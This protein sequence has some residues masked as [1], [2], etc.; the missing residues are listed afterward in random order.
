MVALEQVTRADGLD[1]VLELLARDGAVIVR[2]M[3]APDVL[4]RFR[5]DMRAA[6]GNGSIGPNVDHP[7]IREFWGDRTM[8]FT[9]LAHRSRAFIDILTDPL[10]LAV[11]DATLLPNCNDYWM[12]TGQMMII[13]P[14]EDAQYL[15]RDAANWPT[16]SRPDGFEVTVSCMYA[17]TDFTAEVGATRVVPGSH[18]W[19]D[20]QRV[21]Q[22]H[23]ICQTVMPAG[24]GMIY[25]GR[26]LH[27]AGANVTTDTTR[28]GL[29]LS[30]VLGWLTP[31]EA[32]PLGTPWEDVRDHGPVVQRLLGWRCS[33]HGA[34]IWTVDYND[35]PEG[36]G[37]V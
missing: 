13:A 17:V 27:G 26:V 35:V 33:H 9:R 18:K 12:N 34:R 10:Y 21:A 1:T 3:V 22:P 15:H 8:R 2:D 37:L 32:G 6:A 25:T 19:D 20:Y 16:M 28:F 30:Y 14:G 5:D 36:L 4:G 29:H 31:E 11:A 23:E 24:G 7:E